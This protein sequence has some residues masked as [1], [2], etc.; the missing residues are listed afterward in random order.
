[1]IAASG[2]EEGRGGGKKEAVSGVEGRSDWLAVG[3]LTLKMVLG[4]ASY[5]RY[6][7]I[8]STQFFAP[9]WPIL[10]G[11][12]VFKKIAIQKIGPVKCWIKD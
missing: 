6:L 4:P 1:M 5:I 7:A 9:P 2:D 8:S 10:N 11:T 12:P 3:F